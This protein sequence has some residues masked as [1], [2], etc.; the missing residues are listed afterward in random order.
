LNRQPPR[1]R[2]VHVVN[3]VHEL[4]RNERLGRDA[5]L[6]TMVDLA[7]ACGV[8][9]NA[10]KRAL[11]ELRRAGVIYSVRGGGSYVLDP[12]AR[13]EPGDATTIAA[14][15]EQVR[16]LS[17]RTQI[18]EDLLRERLPEGTREAAMT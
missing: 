11:H 8:G 15:E 7:D 16:A 14:L 12:E 18:L 13:A 2:Y 1:Q 3:H 9:L 17:N 4:I 10:V 6:P 5:P